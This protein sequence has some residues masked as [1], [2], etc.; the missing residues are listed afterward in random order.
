[1]VANKCQIQM[2]N[3][4][5][6]GEDHQEWQC[7]HAL[8]EAEREISVGFDN[9]NSTFIKMNVN[10]ERA[11][12]SALGHIRE[13]QK[14]VEELQSVMEEHTVLQD[15]MKKLERYKRRTEGWKRCLF[16]ILGCETIRRV[17]EE[18]SRI[19]AHEY[20]EDLRVE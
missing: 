10:P 14:K 12:I 18:V 7:P 3:G 8:S 9:P 20:D 5:E 17:L 1:M 16:H 2:P 19:K 13:L 15:R 11:F 6:C 4:V